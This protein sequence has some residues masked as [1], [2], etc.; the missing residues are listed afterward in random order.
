M[1]QTNGKI[2]YAHEL[3]ELILLKWIYYRRQSRNS[4]LFPPMAI[5][6]ELEQIILKFVCKFEN[7]YA[8]FV[9]NPE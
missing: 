6:T 1:T 3:E 8:K 9:I 5:F 4:I 2:C 7:L